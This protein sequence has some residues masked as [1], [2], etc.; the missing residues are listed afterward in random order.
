MTHIILR[1]LNNATEVIC[2]Y[3]YISYFLSTLFVQQAKREELLQYVQA[4]ISGLKMN[5]DLMRL[6][7]NLSLS[8]PLCPRY[9]LLYLRR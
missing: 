3:T 1:F 9:L 7:Q 2:T 6:L 8:M 4:S 5:A